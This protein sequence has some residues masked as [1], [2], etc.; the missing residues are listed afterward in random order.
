L[1]IA[2]LA[3]KNNE[4]IIEYNIFGT[5]EFMNLSIDLPGISTSIGGAF[6]RIL[7][8]F[9][10]VFSVVCLPRILRFPCGT[11]CDYRMFIIP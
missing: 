5:C 11:A 1:I 4:I 10:G 7:R 2:V 3:V 6:L 8:N 9:L